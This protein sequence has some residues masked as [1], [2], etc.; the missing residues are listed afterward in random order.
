MGTRTQADVVGYRYQGSTWC[1]LDLVMH[2]AATGALTVDILAG[3]SVEEVIGR[4]ASVLGIDY[5]DSTSYTSARFPQPILR[6]TADAEAFC[7][8]CDRLLSEPPTRFADD[9]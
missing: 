5:Q 4:Q 2:L 8:A 3:E 1:P 6:G 9:A 7:D